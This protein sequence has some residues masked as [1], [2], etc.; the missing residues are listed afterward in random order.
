MANLLRDSALLP[1]AILA[2]VA[3]LFLVLVSVLPP[4][5]VAALV[6]GKV[7]AIGFVVSRLRREAAGDEP[8]TRA[9]AQARG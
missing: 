9:Q 1:S 2:G 7:L 3:V 5:H 8:T 4:M 6:G